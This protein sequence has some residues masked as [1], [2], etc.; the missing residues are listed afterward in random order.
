MDTNHERF[1]ASIPGRGTA[2]VIRCLTAALLIGA[3]ESVLAISDGELNRKD[4]RPVA[5][6]EPGP[7]ASVTLPDFPRADNI[8][9]LDPDVFG[10]GARVFL[11]TAAISQT[12]DGAVYYTMLILSA[13]GASNIFYEAIQCDARKWRS[14]AYGTHQGVFRPVADNSWRTLRA[15]GTTDY[16]RTLARVYVCAN[17]RVVDRADYLLRILRNQSNLFQDPAANPK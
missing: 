2:Y 3:A 11:D 12:E 10:G 16:R 6:E 9:E 13:S 7:A 14:F 8:V 1:V 15:G 17:D 4:A 5:P